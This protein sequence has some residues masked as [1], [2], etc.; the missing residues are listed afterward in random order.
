VGLSIDREHFE[1]SEF[2]RFG[3]RLRRS[4][5]AL[6]HLLERP[7]FGLGPPSLGAE[8]ELFLVDAAARPL[9]VNE[10][11]VEGSLDPRLTVELDRFNVECN[12]R[13]GPLAGRPFGA[14]AREMDDA[15]AAVRRAARKHGGRVAA[16]GIL[17]TLR[18]AD[19]QSAAM[20]DTPRFRA[21][22]AGVRRLRREPF[23]VDIDGD[24]PLEIT[25]DD[26]TFEG[27]NTSFQLHLRVEPARFA[28]LYNAV[29]M[30]T[31]PALAAA[32]NSPTFLGHRLWQETR[33]AL[34]KQS[35]D[36]RGRASRSS[37]VARVSFGSE[38]VQEGAFEL[39][40]ESVALHEPLL[41]VLSD[42]DP[43]AC[44]RAGGVPRLDEV[45]LHQGTVWR[46]NRAIYDP[47]EGGHLRIE[48]RALP[49]GPSV[50]DMIA[51]AAFLVGLSQKLAPDVAAWTR[52]FSFERAQANFYRAAQHGLDAT[53]Y[54]PPA[55]GAGSR[56]TRARDLVLRLVPSARAGLE[57]AGVDPEE[58]AAVL[59]PLEARAASGRTGAVWQRAVL[60]RLE[61]RLGRDAALA[62]MLELYL[63]GSESGEP[64][65]RW[66]LESE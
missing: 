34:F 54:W 22:N 24:D 61:P 33:V 49:A 40:L 29:Q 52:G 32:V 6:R 9:P 64:V 38:W 3:E 15:L 63:R 62:E 46:W 5:V 36:D 30:A 8:L 35:V 14:L 16:I 58:A 4:L 17:P 51:N 18:A 12:L 19:L 65:H 56:P 42:E 13:H 53:L 23:R 60:D 7:G 21:L 50:P 2:E 20:T 11:V 10:A 1:E 57:D 43:V 55:P 45:R 48:M 27:A 31:A 59:R 25:C 44:T 41:P 37:R 47:R 39:F 26:V 28:R 66:P